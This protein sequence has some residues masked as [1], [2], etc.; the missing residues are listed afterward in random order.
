M[1]TFFNPRNYSFNL[2]REKVLDRRHLN[3]NITEIA[4][5]HFRQPYFYLHTYIYIG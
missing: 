1:L 3:Q 2:R 4:T 5:K